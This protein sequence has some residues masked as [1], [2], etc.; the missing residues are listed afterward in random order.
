MEV[1]VTGPLAAVDAKPEKVVKLRGTDQVSHS[2]SP[3]CSVFGE[4]EG[5]GTQGDSHLD[6]AYVEEIRPSVH[7]D[8]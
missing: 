5:A 7:D 6:K 3:L 8:D 2:P 1:L 4:Y